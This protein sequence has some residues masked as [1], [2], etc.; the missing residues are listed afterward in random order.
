M[1]KI[2]K[3]YVAITPG[4]REFIKH[5]IAR[6]GIGPQK[7]LKGNKEAKEAGLT[8]GIIYG[9]LGMNSNIKSARKRHVDLALRLWENH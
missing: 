9:I 6:T 2:R 1:N 4:I 3:G 5:E 7:A 8:S